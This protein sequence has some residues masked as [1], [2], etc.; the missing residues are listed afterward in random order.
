MNMIDWS[1]FPDPSA[2]NFG[3]RLV[4]W[5]RN[6][7]TDLH[8]GPGRPIAGISQE[9]LAGVLGVRKQTV[10]MWERGIKPRPYIL[11]RLEALRWGGPSV[12]KVL[13]IEQAEKKFR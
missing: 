13:A 3:P 9:R 1:T 10:L 8:R 6:Q 11:E 2:D 7:P 5:R 4:E 12:V